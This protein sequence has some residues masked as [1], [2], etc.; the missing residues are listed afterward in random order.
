MSKRIVNMLITMFIVVVLG[1]YLLITYMPV[2]LSF[3]GSLIYL[4]LMLGVIILLIYGL[5][6]LVSYINR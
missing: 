5:Y 3:A 4:L 2:L 6:K 1:G